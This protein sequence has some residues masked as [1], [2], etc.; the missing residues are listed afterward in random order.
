MFVS[1]I[2]RAMFIFIQDSL[3]FTNEEQYI[4]DYY[5]VTMIRFRPVF[6]DPVQ[7]PCFSSKECDDAHLPVGVSHSSCFCG[8]IR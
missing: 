6:A 3:L 1:F 7:N 5:L 2:L 4:C 8:C